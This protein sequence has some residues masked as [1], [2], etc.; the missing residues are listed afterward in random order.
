MSSHFTKDTFRYFDLAKKN[1]QNEKW[2]EKNINLYLEEVKEPFGI[3]LQQLKMR[4]GDDLPGI[5]I[6]PKKI[7]RPL[8][9]KNK[10]APG[11]GIIK[12]QS[13]ATLWEK[14]VSLFEWNPGY[15]IQLGASDEDNF[16]GTGLYMISSR[17]LKLMR[18]KITDHFEEFD[19]IMNNKKFKKT[20]GGLTGDKYKRF[21]K[22][23]DENDPAALYLWHKQFY[24]GKE[25]TRKEALDKKFF[26]RLGDDLALTVP[27]FQWV[28]NAVGKYQKNKFEID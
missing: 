7:T 1:A 12:S 24:V 3:L 14:R 23:F 4:L 26:H 21:P 13:H 16:Y 27:F 28:R 22:D 6:D 11:E 20:F 5:E 17:Q 9:A 8:K 19:A 18:R 10:M 2:L 15:H 25:F